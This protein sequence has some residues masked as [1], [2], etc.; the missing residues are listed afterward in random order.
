LVVTKLAVLTGRKEHAARINAAWQKTVGGILETGDRLHDAR[1]GPDQLPH[2]EFEKMVREDLN[3]DPSVARKLMAIASN[4]ALA[5]RAHAHVLP[6]RWMTLY[7]LAVAANKGFDLEAGIASGDIHPRML[8]KDVRALLPP[9]PQRD[10]DLP[11][12]DD[13]PTADTSAADTSA[14]SNPGSS[15]RRRPSALPR[16]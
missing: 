3:F 9:P 16:D 7:E 2:G 5:N 10:D 4:A 12:D 1:T 15:W 8:R 6:A 14:G 11:D 13:M